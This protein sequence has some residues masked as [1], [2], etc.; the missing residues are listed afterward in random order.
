MW[1]AVKIEVGAVDCWFMNACWRWD[2][3]NFIQETESEHKRARI[4][5]VHSGSNASE[6]NIFMRRMRVPWL[7]QL[8]NRAEATG[9]VP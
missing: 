1:E 7:M 5:G 6:S 8:H 9:Q 2:D 3:K 4:L